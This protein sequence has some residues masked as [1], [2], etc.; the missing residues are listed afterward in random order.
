[1]HLLVSYKNIYRNVGYK[2]KFFRGSK[3]IPV[4]QFNSSLMKLKGSF[5]CLYKL[6]KQKLLYI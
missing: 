2:E 5:S 1:M 3:L 6:Y 4:I